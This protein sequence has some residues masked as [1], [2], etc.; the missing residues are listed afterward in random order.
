MR[1]TVLACAFTLATSSW[2]E[3]PIRPERPASSA[4]GWCATSD[5][6]NQEIERVNRWARARARLRGVSPDAAG[7]VRQENGVHIITGTELMIPFHNPVDLTGSSI[8]YERVDAQTY[9]VSRTALQYDDNVGTNLSFRGT[10]TYPLAQTE[11]PFYGQTLRTLYIN[12]LFSIRTQ[13]SLASDPPRQY[14]PLELLHEQTPLIAP[15]LQ[16]STPPPVT[17]GTRQVYVRETADAV[18]VTWRVVRDP[19]QQ[20]IPELD[21]DIDL[22]ARLQRD[23]TIIFSYRKATNVTWGAAVITPGGDRWVG[24]RT[25][26]AQGTDPAGDA[27]GG[28]PW[29]ALTDI[30]AVEISRVADTDLLDIRVR[31]GGSLTPASVPAAGSVVGVWLYDSSGRMDQLNAWVDPN[32]MLFCLPTWTC[33]ASETFVRFTDNSLWIRVLESQLTVSGTDLDYEVHTWSPAGH[34]D[35][36]SGTFNRGASGRNAELDLSALSQPATVSGPA[37]EAFTLPILNVAAVYDRLRS[38]YGL[39]DAEIDGVAIY[40]N[41]PTDIILYAG[42]Y[43][44][45]G[46]SGAD[47]IISGRSNTGSSKPRIPA[48]LHMNRLYLHRADDDQYSLRVLGHELG[49]R[50][51]YH[52]R[53]QENGTATRSLNPVSAHPAAFVHTPAAFPVFPGATRESSTMGGGWFIEEAGTFR[54]GLVYNTGFS[55]LDLYLMGLA[56]PQE[57]QAWFYIADSAPPLPREYYPPSNSAFWGVKKDVTMEQVTAAMGQRWPAAEFS[58]RRF[59]TLFVL[60]ESPEAPASQ[61]QVAKTAAF[62]RNFEWYMDRATGG[63]A[64]TTAALP[65]RPTASFTNTVVSSRL[66]QFR[67]TSADYPTSWSWSF[68]DGAT[69]TEQHPR[70]TYASS[71]RYTVTLQVRNSRGTSTRTMEIEVGAGQGRRRAVRH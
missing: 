4:D 29:T 71:G 36:A 21:P 56:T 31:L 45:V 33:T 65:V 12:D 52:L 23:G 42:A 38:A 49:H 14:G 66:V 62:A 22:Q 43:S 54:T 60:L 63:R 2:A 55:W 61:E 30:R 20:P 24:N 69:S 51:L 47:G 58:Q 17:F 18:T 15:L 19:R 59:R 57:A 13:A 32:D 10:H 41:F 39:E 53:I 50:W 67:D 37:V 8:R 28:T 5:A 3:S 34:S 68:G 64:S 25:A 9:R 11:V 7:A 27:G 70:H 16:A 6:T 40:Q 46:N 1:L 35:S 26:L 44:T 48:L